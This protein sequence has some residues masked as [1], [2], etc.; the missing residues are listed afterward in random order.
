[1]DGPTNGEKKDCGACRGL[2]E[3]EAGPEAPI[4][5]FDDPVAS[6]DALRS[7]RG[8]HWTCPGSA[9]SALLCPG[10]NEGLQVAFTTK[11]ME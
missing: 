5:P 10:Y 8:R 4:S 11:D 7:T 1:M 3:L 6:T 2:Q 9:R